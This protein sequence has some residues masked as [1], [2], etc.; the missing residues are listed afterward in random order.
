MRITNRSQR[1]IFI[2]TTMIGCC[3]SSFEV[4]AQRSL[5]Q[6]DKRRIT[7]IAKPVI[8][9]FNPDPSI[10]RAGED[11]YIITSSN[12]FF[13]GLP[14]YHS[15]DLI[16][17]KMIGHVLSDPKHLDLDS[18]AGSKGLY[19][20]TIRFHDGMFY[21]TCTLTGSLP[22]KPSGNFI[23]TA[24][25]PRGPWSP[26]V[27]L[28]APGIDPSL[29]FDEDGKVYY[30][31]NYTPEDKK[32]ARHRKIYLQ[33]ID[34]K[35]VKLVGPRV[36]ILDAADYYQKGTIDGGSEFGADYLEAPHLY[37]KD[38]YYYLTTSH[39]G[40]FQQHALSFWR[41]RQIFGPYASNPANPILTHRMLPP[42]F[43]VT[44]TGHGDLVS[45]VKN[46][47]HM[48]FLARRPLDS[49]IHIL[50]RETFLTPIDWKDDWP[51]LPDN[52][53]PVL[54]SQQLLTSQIP[55]D[56][57]SVRRIV[58]KDGRLSPEW[59]FIRTPREN[60]WTVNVQKY[61]VSIRLRPDM[62]SDI[63]QPSWL[64]LRQ[65]RFHARFST[66]MEFSPE[67]EG[68]EAGLT[69]FRDK[70]H[71]FKFTLMRTKE[72]DMLQLSKRSIGQITDQVI[73]R[74][75]YPGKQLILRITSSG[76]W[77]SFEYGASDDQLKYLVKDIDGAFLGSPVAGKFTGTM[78]GV[79]A[80]SNGMESSNSVVFRDVYY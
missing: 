8:P 5:Q 40:T 76:R 19:A 9:G 74:V 58:I 34:L 79:Y 54:Q 51:Q 27:W 12:E 78:I 80:S 41:S 59:T 32:W 47:W 72:G 63:S 65:D 1:V 66:I 36:D 46:Q 17:W 29:F 38:G 44:S 16:D 56:D 37:K 24:R 50:G 28:D 42:T 3:Y 53:W 15:R 39:G 22:G 57:T 64:G 26:P 71:Y 70:D 25:D 67:A 13:P 45:D 30:Q 6:D 23:T 10:C 52:H 49:N 14:I 2:L 48:A 55:K 69:V 61:A 18:I 33:E 20:P 62:L 11:Y 60:W 7:P 73:F 31:G 43:A 35:R 68:E 4:L 21:V 77:Y 75:P